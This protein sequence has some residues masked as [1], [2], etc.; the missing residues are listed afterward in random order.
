MIKQK[1]FMGVDVS[2]DK[3]DIALDGKCYEI[4]N[5]EK[6]ISTF[7]KKKRL[8]GD[9]PSL[10]V[11][12]STGGYEK[13]LRKQLHH[14]GIETH[15]GHPNRVKAYG[16]VQGHYAKT[17]RLDALLI[18]AYAKHISPDA[19]IDIPMTKAQEELSELRSLERSL[20]D[21]LHAMK[22]R[23]DHMKSAISQEHSQTYIAAIVNHLTHVRE[24]IKEIISSD[25]T[26]MEHKRIMMSMTGV[27]EVTANVLL[28]DLPELGKLTK[29]E[30]ASLTGLAPKTC[31]S[32]KKTWSAHIR[33][34]R[35]YI[36]KAL[37]MAAMSAHRFNPRL[38]VVY[39]RLRE[40]GKPFKV[41]IVAIMRK[42]IVMLNAMIRKKQLCVDF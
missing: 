37:Y 32:G 6:A 23:S 7:I 18:E 27:G 28:C 38:V 19:R 42:I 33:G 26:M 3:L 17:D 31:M 34:G 13:C 22:C 25:K 9:C 35:F 16:T 24:A 39:N 12:E 8:N 10:V 21:D 14:F 4:A 41:A 36:R 2:K 15:T 30:I 5:T 40:A 11:F 29:P 1:V 20:A